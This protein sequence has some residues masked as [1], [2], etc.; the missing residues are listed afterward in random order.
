MRKKRR[1]Q[2][3]KA[4]RKQIEKG[5]I[6]NFIN[7]EMKDL[8]CIKISDAASESLE[9]GPLKEGDSLFRR[10]ENI[11]DSFLTN[12]RKAK[13][14]FMLEGYI[15][16]ALN[17]LNIIKESN[18][19]LAKDSYVFP[20]LFNFR[21]YLELTM[22]E[23][24]SSFEKLGGQYKDDKNHTLTS[25]W[26]SLYVFLDKGDKELP[27]VGKLI[28]EFDDKD[29][30]SMAF[31]YPYQKGKEGELQQEN[32][33]NDLI[34]IENLRTKMLQLYRFF[35]GVSELANVENTDV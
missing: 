2:F 7:K 5:A 28:Q 32:S 27:V 15:N 4:F 24:I 16:S 14:L 21:Q 34:D 9:V 25:L 22:K 8:S 11:E 13:G 20:A 23:S 26:N 6:R 33:F 12:S 3:K 18:G 19:N 35:E 1:Y 30:Y 10:S 29:R 31:R 17:L